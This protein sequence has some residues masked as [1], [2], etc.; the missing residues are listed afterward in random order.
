[1]CDISSLRVN[2]VRSTYRRSSSS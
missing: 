2:K 1:M